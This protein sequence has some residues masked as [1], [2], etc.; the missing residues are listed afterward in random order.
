L[1]LMSSAAICLPRASSRADARAAKVAESRQVSQ[2]RP[3][4]KPQNKP[5]IV[6]GKSWLS[7]DETPSAPK[8]PP[9]QVRA[10]A[11]TFYRR[12]RQ[13]LVSER[14]CLLAHSRRHQRTR[15]QPKSP[16]TRWMLPVTR[17]KYLITTSAPSEPRA[18]RIRGDRCKC[19]TQSTVPSQIH[20]PQL[21]NHG[22]LLVKRTTSTFSSSQQH[23]LPSPESEP[24][25][26]RRQAAF[27]HHLAPDS[28]LTTSSLW[29]FQGGFVSAAIRDEEQQVESLSSAHASSSPNVLDARRTE[30]SGWTRRPALS[31]SRSCPTGRTRSRR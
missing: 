10:D 7:S 11:L 9:V 18:H 27:N 29:N 16:Q 21:S 30:S 20:T 17:R 28:R 12:P 26:T 6:M 5:Q 8:R 31:R 19:R 13:R 23:S 3:A 2:A 22:P 25:S 4:K 15:L 1:T 24:G 14:A